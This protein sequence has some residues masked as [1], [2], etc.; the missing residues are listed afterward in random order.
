M[1]ESTILQVD[2]IV[3]VKIITA[4]RP[5][6]LVE[7]DDGVIHPL[8]DCDWVF[9]R[10]CGCPTGTRVAV[11]GDVVLHSEQVAM[12]YVYGDGTKSRTPKL[13]AAKYA[14]GTTAVLMTHQ[15]WIDAVSPAMAVGCPHR[16]KPLLPTGAGAP[17]TESAEMTRVG[18][19]EGARHA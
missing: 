18:S 8:A 15:Q 14:A 10:S 4:S 13:V 5:K 2:K 12:A 3:P 7:L 1:V 11:S 17:G 16:A 6:L 9:Y 19:G